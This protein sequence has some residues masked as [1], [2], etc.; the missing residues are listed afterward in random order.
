MMDTGADVTLI[1]KSEWLPD[2]EFEPV[3]GC[4]SGIGGVATSW[5][6]KTNVVVGVPEG[7]MATVT[8]FVVRAPITLWH[9]DVLSQWAAMLQISF[10]DF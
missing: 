5:R 10:R 2:W 4:I 3:V 6:S 7:K 9:H 1:A 8:P